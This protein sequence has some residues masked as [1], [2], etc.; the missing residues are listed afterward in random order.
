VVFAGLAATL[1]ALFAV[2]TAAQVKAASGPY[3][4]AVD[5]SY[6]A[7]V[8]PIAERSSSIG[9][10]VRQVLTKG[11]TY[12]RSTLFGELDSVSSGAEEG[13]DNLAGLVPPSPSS[14]S[15]DKCESALDHR[16][17]A[18]S[19]LRESIEGLLGGR[20]G[21]RAE[22]PAAVD[23]ALSGVGRA[24]EISDSEWR[25]CRRALASSP[26]SARIPASIWVPD[27]SLWAPGSVAGFVT[28]LTQSPSLAVV[29][30]LTI[31]ANSVTT[32]PASVAVSNGDGVIPPTSSLSV[33]VVVANVGSVDEPNAVV[34]VSAISEG[35]PL[36]PHAPGRPSSVESQTV[37]LAAGA[38]FAANPPPLV[39]VPGNV[40]SI[41]VS[42]SSPSAPGAGDNLQLPLVIAQ[43]ASS[44]SITSSLNP[45]TASDRVTYTATVTAAGASVTPTGIMTFSDGSEA[46][47]GCT[48]LR[49]SNASATCTVTYP[50]AGYHDM[51]AAYSGNSQIAGSSS[52]LLI[53]T[54]VPQ[55]R[56]RTTPT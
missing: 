35:T 12:D 30:Q 53:Q 55:R 43:V 44:V 23:S 4:R 39:V 25:Q 26:G 5:R 15:A 24:L 29:H 21:R 48:A 17:T 33:Q 28:A 13:A 2:G 47:P 56:N 40:Y 22:S 11:A 19:N 34:R 31:P 16:A 49:V 38:T 27:S 41:D 10:T 32:Q 3:R 46:V 14:T 6:A 1:V 54:V 50:T 9:A 8:V 37:S 18:A 51:T 42:V 20:A 7:L 45:S 52:A 36:Q